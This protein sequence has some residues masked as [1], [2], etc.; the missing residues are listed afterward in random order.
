MLKK[1]K[2][3]VKH[4]HCAMAVI[5]YKKIYYMHYFCVRLFPGIRGVAHAWWSVF[6]SQAW[7]QSGSSHT[8]PKPAGAR[9]I[10]SVQTLF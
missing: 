10:R 6:V 9:P 8:K 2:I 5:I 7:K 1:I 3:N 4:S